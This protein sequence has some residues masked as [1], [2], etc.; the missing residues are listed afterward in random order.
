MTLKLKSIGPLPRLTLRSTF[1]LCKCYVMLEWQYKNVN[2]FSL[3][4]MNSTSFIFPLSLCVFSL[5]SLWYLCFGGLYW[6]T[7]ASGRPGRGLCPLRQQK[8]TREKRKEKQPYNNLLTMD[9]LPP[10]GSGQQFNMR[11]WEWPA[12]DQLP[13]KCLEGNPWQYN[14]REV[15]RKMVNWIQWEELEKCV[16]ADVARKAVVAQ[17]V[18]MLLARYTAVRMSH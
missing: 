16:R 11:S 1:I 12:V 17:L 9:W 8:K 2:L 13:L 5:P 14:P 3:S 7:L 15:K 6:T 10:R 4:L 18:K